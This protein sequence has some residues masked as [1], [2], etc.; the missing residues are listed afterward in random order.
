MEI[1]DILLLLLGGVIG[2]AVIV[3]WNYITRRR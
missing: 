2:L 1:T 3:L